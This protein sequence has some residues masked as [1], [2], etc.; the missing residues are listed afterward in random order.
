MEPEALRFL[1]SRLK[2]AYHAA[3]ASI[4]GPGG[5]AAD[6][7]HIVKQGTVRGSPATGMRA[8]KLVDLVHGPGE[9]FPVGALIGRRETAYQ[10]RADSD[11]FAYELAAE[12]FHA[13]VGRSPRFQRF[14]TDHLASLLAQSH[15]AL[16][17]QAA[18]AL[19]DES[20][21]LMP[22]RGL[23]RRAA[24]SCAPGTPI[25]DVLEAM[26][27]HAV[28]S[29]VVVDATGAPVGIL[30]QPD[31]LSRVALAGADLSG[32]VSCVMTPDPVL[33]QAEAPVHQAA[34]AMARHGIRH[35]ILVDE[36]R[37]AGVVSERDL[38]SV[39]RVSLR[40]TADRISGAADRAALSDAAA[41][42]RA[43]A[44]S[45][46]AQGLGAEQLTQVISAMNDA[47]VLRAV[48]LAAPAHPI[49]GNWC[50]IALGSE[51]RTEQ[52]LST[53]QDNALILERADDTPSALAFAAVVNE[54]LDA[55]GF[56]LCRGDIMA[57]N[58]RWCL[59][60][61]RWRET[62]SDWI[63]NPVPDAL[64]NAAIF[65]DLR[66]LAGDA[67]L[68]DTLRGWL[69]E[70][71]AA[72]A[73]FL[74]GMAVN[75]L[76]ARPPLGLL[77]EFATDGTP[78][79]PGTLDLK[80]LGVRPSIDAAR[81]WALS[82]GLPQTST[83]ERLREAAR[84]GILPADEAAS[85]VDAFHFLQAMRLRHQHFQR[86]AAGAENRI[87]PEKLNSLDRRILKEA[88]RHAAKLQERL[89]LDFQL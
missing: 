39:Q 25:R 65:F 62:F 26:H 33:V 41:A 1:A 27:A 14:C 42:V 88:F 73:G 20:R 69:L 76:K 16:R 19:M 75:A 68:A 85:A 77:R 78:G 23:V 2:L 45:L 89:R 47:I 32:P 12:D 79:H 86:P 21:M 70:R 7:L 18:E 3:G 57:R 66:P 28:G 6:R 46:L 84:A 71:T 29:M 10:Y 59:T 51:G 53:D 9:C 37:L 8:E 31:V 11:V 74:R 40:G 67:R 17:A 64:M 87:D 48:R 38:F 15:R 24:V 30:T 4:A 13:L 22:L 81:V 34:L 55:C 60:G 50:W 36:G 72:N 49:A 5:G 80:Q 54:T 61:E 58:P 83:A 35:V 82:R 63:R 43:L 56:P 52:T 44:G